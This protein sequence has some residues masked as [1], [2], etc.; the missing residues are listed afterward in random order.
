EIPEFTNEYR[1]K[2]K[3]NGHKQ[4]GFVSALLYDKRMNKFIFE[5]RGQDSVKNKQRDIEKVFD[6]PDRFDIKHVVKLE[7][8]DTITGDDLLIYDKQNEMLYKQKD[9]FSAMS[10]E[11]LEETGLDIK[12]IFCEIKYFGF[13]KKIFETD[14]IITHVFLIIFD[15]YDFIPYSKEKKKGNKV[16]ALN[17]YD[18]LKRINDDKDKETK[19][20]TPTIEN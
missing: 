10:R 2:R 3:N 14:G 6:A 5:L 19:Y 7:K 8:W 18:I 11:V 13:D 17:S 4:Y 12:K 16:I 9:I 1:I 20:F 15:S